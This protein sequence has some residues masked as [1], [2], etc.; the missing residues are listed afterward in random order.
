MSAA[1]AAVGLSRPQAACAPCITVDSQG[2][3][4]YRPYFQRFNVTPDSL[5]AVW[6]NGADKPGEHPNT[7]DYVFVKHYDPDSVPMFCGAN[8]MSKG[9]VA[10][11]AFTRGR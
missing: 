6:F 4:S 2:H 7:A 5:E 3:C 8:Y 11:P 9:P 10:I 1:R